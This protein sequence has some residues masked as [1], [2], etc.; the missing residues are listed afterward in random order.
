[1]R[2]KGLCRFF[3]VF[4]FSPFP[5]P[6]SCYSLILSFYFFSPFSLQFILLFLSFSFFSP[7]PFSSSLSLSY[8]LCLPLSQY[9]LSLHF[10]LSFLS[11]SFFFSLFSSFSSHSSYFLLLFSTFPPYFSFQIFLSP[12][13]LPV[14]LILTFKFFS[15]SSL[16]TLHFPLHYSSLS[17]FCFPSLSLS[18][19]SF[20]PSYSP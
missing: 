15:L 7:S 2:K 1:M 5:F 18:E 8:L 11:I 13:L 9:L 10:L 6:F 12:S 3:S 4:S 17:L 14:S 20:F 16:P 19:L